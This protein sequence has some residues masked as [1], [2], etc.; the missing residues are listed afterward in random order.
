MSL[1]VTFNFYNEPNEIKGG[2]LQYET[3]VALKARLWKLNQLFSFSVNGFQCILCKLNIVI[4]VYFRS[5]LYFFSFDF[6]NPVVID[7]LEV[8]LEIGIT[9]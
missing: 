2:F 9:Q 6:F 1:R 3:I 8:D 4:T 5:I 7:Y